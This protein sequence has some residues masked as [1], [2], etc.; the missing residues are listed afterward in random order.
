MLSTLAYWTL[1]LPKPLKSQLFSF[2]LSLPN[3]NFVIADKAHVTESVCCYVH[4]NMVRAR[5]K[6][7]TTW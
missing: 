1:L 5:S 6:K 2:T 4:R 7:A 3:I